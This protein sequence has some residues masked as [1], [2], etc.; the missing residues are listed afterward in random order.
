MSETTMREK[1]EAFAEA[2]VG[3]RSDAKTHLEAVLGLHGVPDVADLVDRPPCPIEAPTLNDCVRGQPGAMLA[4]R[5]CTEYAMSGPRP[6][7]EAR[8][9]AFLDL[10]QS[11]V[12]VLRPEG[13]PTRQALLD[14]LAEYVSRDGAANRVADGPPDAARM[15]ELTERARAALEGQ[16]KEREDPK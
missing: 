14:L 1:A 16:S 11:Y 6:G 9:D 3:H 12:D 8:R 13:Y 4:M 10:L 7:W 15:G 2:L 5:R